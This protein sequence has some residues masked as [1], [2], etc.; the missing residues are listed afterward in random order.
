MKKICLIIFILSSFRPGYSQYHTKTEY[1]DY[2]NFERS[3]E[4]YIPKKY[5]VEFSYPLVFI[6]H[7]GGGTAK[8]LIRSTHSRFNQLAEQDNFI[9][10]YPNGIEKSWNDGARDSVGVARKLNI[11]DVGFFEE[12]MKN[13]QS[14]FS[15]DKNKIFV[16]GISN[17]GFMAQ[18]LAFELSDKIKGIGVVAANLSKVLEKQNYPKNR[19]SAI[20]INGTDD[21]I[22]PY[23]GGQVTVFRKKR[24]EIFSVAETITIWK[25]INSCSKETNRFTFPDTNIDDNCTALKTE[26]QNPENLNI[27]VTAIT[28]KNGGHTW[29]G[30]RRNLPKWLVGNTN[31]DINGCDEIWKFFASLVE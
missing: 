30:S 4:V 31:K 5:S 14:N 3:Y 22:V 6:L 12:M 1:I 25:G 10:V 7:G 28:I 26:W 24:G 23:N 8:G 2:E 15:V 17:G 20:F 21:P 19:V 9:A 13:L 18:R 11:D 29:P 27:K 16:C